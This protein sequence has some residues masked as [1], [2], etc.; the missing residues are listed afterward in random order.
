M[1][2]ELV[3]M[4]NAVTGADKKLRLPI[5]K[6]DDQAILKFIQHTFPTLGRVTLT[7][8]PNGDIVVAPVGGE[9]IAAS[10]VKQNTKV[11]GDGNMINKGIGKLFKG[12]KFGPVKDNRFKM[13]MFGVAVLNTEGSYVVYDPDT[14]SIK[15]VADM[16]FPIGNMVFA[17]P[18]QAP[19]IGD[20]ILFQE[21]PYYIN[22]INATG[23]HG[24]NIIGGTAATIIPQTGLIPGLSFYTKLVSAFGGNF[25]ASGLGGDSNNLLTMMAMSSAFG[26]DNGSDGN[27]MMQLLMLSQV[28]AGGGATA[29]PL[30]NLSSMLPLMMLSG[31]GLGG[32]DDML[33]MMMMLQVMG[34]V[35]GGNPFAAILGGAA[36]APTVS[37]T[38]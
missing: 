31:S 20:T 6:G 7:P 14:N 26:K 15:D 21:N 38:K 30:G 1:A 27:D 33:E 2:K 13:S 5:P 34:G 24:I 36:P 18:V 12:F 11:R 22:D 4:E 25:T 8:M 9:A 28:F 23:I 19:T 35:N 17:I 10:A 29:N 3:F 16:V 37:T 32:G